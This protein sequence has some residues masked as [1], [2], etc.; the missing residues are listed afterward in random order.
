MVRYPFYCTLAKEVQSFPGPG[1]YSGIFAIYYLQ[2]QSNNS[3][4]RTAII[5]YALCLLYFLSTVN[6]VADIVQLVHNV[7]SN[8][9]CKNIIFL[10]VVQSYYI[11]STIGLQTALQS[12]S[13]VQS[14]AS[15]CCDFIAQCI[16]VCINRCSYHP[17]YSPKS[18]K[19][20]RCWIV[21]GHNIHVV[22][23]PSF[24]AITYLGQ[25]IYSYLHLI[26]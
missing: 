9:I 15:G 16:I 10:L 25:S 18:A 21:W 6:F 19:I 5:L 3:R 26:S 2:C 12:I 14:I 17:F 22:I 13:Y 4:T 1:L 23:I 11:G 8:S 20:Y 7:S 24:L